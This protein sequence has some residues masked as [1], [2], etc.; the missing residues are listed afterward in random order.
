MAGMCMNVRDVIVGL[1]GFTPQLVVPEHVPKATFPM[2][3]TPNHTITFKKNH[4]PET[5]IT[6]EIV[7]V[8]VLLPVHHPV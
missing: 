6:P 5:R 2:W 7:P 4:H 8:P 3:D 1:C